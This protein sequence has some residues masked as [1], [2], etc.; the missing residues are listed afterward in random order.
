[1]NK[2]GHS[3]S[4][5]PRRPVQIIRAQPALPTTAD[6]DYN[7]ENHR[8]CNIG[9]PRDDNDAS[10]KK[11]VDLATTNLYNKVLIA[12]EAL[13]ALGVAVDD[14]NDQVKSSMNRIQE[15]DQILTTNVHDDLRSLSDLARETAE[16]MSQL[17]MMWEERFQKMEQFKTTIY[18]QIDQIKHTSNIM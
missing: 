16:K 3:L 14:I 18:H 5:S 11:Y 1:M 13:G 17:S 8:L 12:N 10:N 4:S 15:L 7:V 6:G 9:M 2:F